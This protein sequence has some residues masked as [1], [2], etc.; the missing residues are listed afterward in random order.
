MDFFNIARMCIH[1]A[2]ECIAR[3]HFYPNEVDI[4]LSR[5]QILAE[6]LH[7]FS[8]K[9]SITKN[10]EMVSELQLWNEEVEHLTRLINQ[11]RDHPVYQQEPDRLMTFTTRHYSGNGRPSISINM[12]AVDYM[13]R[14][15]YTKK[16]IAA[17]AGISIRTFIRRYQESGSGTISDDGLD[18]QVTEILQR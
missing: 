9:H 17:M 4:H 13:L 6:Y 16:E 10:A 12:G 18:R 7:Q 15:G 14:L 2:Q 11:E 8:N 1:Q 5:L 3:Q